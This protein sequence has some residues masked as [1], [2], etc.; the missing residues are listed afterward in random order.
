MPPEDNP[1]SKNSPTPE[2]KSKVSIGTTLAIV[3][4]LLGVGTFIFARL[5]VMHDRIGNERENR[6]VVT[7]KKGVVI[8]REG[9]P[10]RF[11]E[12]S[13]SIKEKM[14]KGLIDPNEFFRKR[15]EYDHI[16]ISV[17]NNGKTVAGDVHLE[18]GQYGLDGSI[19][20]SVFKDFDVAPGKSIDAKFSVQFEPME[21]TA[22]DKK[23]SIHGKITYVDKLQV[24]HKFEESFCFDIPFKFDQPEKTERIIAWQEV[25]EPPRDMP[26]CFDD[27]Q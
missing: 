10:Q 15:R 21:N 11:E 2:P 8:A 3:T 18:L 5:D 25:Y 26:L 7:I 6:P 24:T 23:R 13:E 20:S 12:L 27:E 17:D 4:G 22:P 1:K 14:K 16:V 9:V 19:P